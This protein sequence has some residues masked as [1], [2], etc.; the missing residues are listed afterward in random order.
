MSVFVLDLETNPQAR[1]ASLRLTDQ[2]GRHLGANQVKLA[3]QAPSLLEAAFDTRAHV[4]RYAGN[5]RLDD[6]AQP[7]TAEQLL[8]RLGV[9]LGE[10]ILGTEIVGRL[11]QGRAHR[12]LLVRLPDPQADLLAAAFARVPWEI[13]RPAPGQDPL[14]A[15][16]LVVRAVP[17]GTEPTGAEDEAPGLAA[18]E[19]LR[20]LLV[21]AEAP[22]S[23]PLAM[24]QE[25]ERLLG[26]FFDDILPRQQVEVDMLCHGVTRALLR[27]R[28]QTRGGYDVVHWSGHGHHNL[29][30]L[31]GE[32][33]KKDAITGEELVRLFEEAGGF[34]PRLVFLSACLSGA[35]V[36]ARDWGAL[37]AAL[38]GEQ[39]R[40][41]GEEAT[42]GDVLKDKPGYTGSALALLRAGVPQVVAM[43]YEVTDGYARRFAERFYQHLL[44]D[45]ARHPVDTA[46]A[47]ARGDVARGA[48]AGE[49]TPVDHSTP[50]VFGRERLKFQAPKG[51]SAQLARRWPLPRPLLSGGR[52]DL[53]AHPGFVGRGAELSLLS[54]RWLSRGGPAVALVQALAGM[55]K[56]ALAAEAIHLWHGRFDWVFAFQ[57]R[58]TA[59]TVEEFYRQL[60]RR[61]ALE[62]NVYREACQ[63]RPS[64]AVYLPPSQTLSGDER[65]QR[66]RDNLLEVLSR[67]NVLLV[68]DNFETNLATV[69]REDGYRCQD[70]EWDRLLAALAEGLLGTGSRLLVTCRHRVAA[71][72]HE[73]R[74]VWLP[75][76][77]L[78]LAE[79]ALFL[80]GQPNLL[81][82]VLG[83]EA[84]QKL[85]RQVLEVSRGHPLILQRLAGL[86]ADRQAL[87]QALGRL[88]H[89]GL[90]A[91]PDV[92]QGA[93]TGAEREAER[94]YLEEVTVGAI[95]LLL[96]RASPPARR[97]LWVATLANEP[98]SQELLA[99]VWSGPSALAWAEPVEPLLV[100][101]RGAGLLVLEEGAYGFHELVR[102]RA[103][104][105][106]EAHPEERGSHTPE[107]VWRA[108]GDRYADAYDT[109]SRSGKPGAQDQADEAGRRALTY[110]IRSGDFSGRGEFA[111]RLV[112]DTHN[113]VLLR[114]AIVQLQ[115]VADRV[116]PG[117][118]RW[119]V[120]TNLAD[121][122]HQAA[123]PDQAVSLYEQAAQEAEQAEDWLDAQWICGNWAN[124]MAAIGQLSQARL[125]FQRSAEFG[126]RADIP[127]IHVIGHE[128]G[129][130]SID[131][132]QGQAAK[133]LPEVERRLEEVRTWYKRSCQGERVPEAPQLWFLQRVLCAALDFARMA[134]MA[135][136]RVEACL[137]L[138][139][140]CEQV[141]REKGMS[142]YEL[143]RTR[144]NRYGA[145][146]ELGRLPEAK[147]LL[148]DCLRVCQDVQDFGGQA[149]ALS[150]LGQVWQRIGDMNQAIALERQA[151]ALWERLPD[152]CG[153]SGSHSRLADHLRY[154]GQL[155]EMSR[156]RLAA[157]VYNMVTF[158]YSKLANT[159]YNIRVDEQEAAAAGGRYNLPR[160][161]ALVQ[162]PEF[163][164]LRVF[165]EESGRTPAEFQPAIDKVPELARSL[166]ERVARQRG[167]G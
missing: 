12:T 125:T 52:R 79:A 123:Q 94:R 127:R 161:D 54:R 106:M 116:P 66:L 69:P 122:L 56:T 50:L 67:E 38:R 30:E 14:L 157:L 91:L 167:P 76:G 164:A 46:L 8:E 101:L 165:L 119:R 73:G 88:R 131:V 148:E 141:Q 98:V 48:A 6:S 80:K 16:N 114:S 45:P 147:E 24:R 26:L 135:L 160:L 17:A 15:R 99:S 86:A 143:A 49:Y 3:D 108:Y 146:I 65:Y 136:G 109:H 2:H 78:P 27:E 97:L 11:A 74:V 53:D 63:E 155:E 162:R 90:K 96:E 120:R 44:A 85:A 95:D 93:Q 84:D 1:L 149:M 68:L 152:P 166:M 64:A 32:D 145:L 23:R 31:V 37:R 124:A 21:F 40:K 34:I 163:D 134:N 130:L 47:L 103:A 107:Q 118:Q 36:R 58:P 4:E 42:L 57:A 89:D 115:E 77:P 5:L 100:E 22:G 71:L 20:V 139:D 92:F 140:E 51:R 19:P 144:F 112:T 33:G 142:E 154:A 113:P 121:A 82:L 133:A 61:L 43:R 153:R 55:G 150:G 159:M 105:W 128:L 151:L 83:G 7:A 60:D 29:L 126:R 81:K 9:F 18:D 25:R 70:P 62:S 75:L 110:V 156:H 41:S 35:L 72:A 102:E 111:S 158:G 59:L 104:A 129:A 39:E 28:V 10:K 87:E 138:M 132:M 117:Q 137:H 13:A